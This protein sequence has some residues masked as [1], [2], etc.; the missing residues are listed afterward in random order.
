MKNNR[1]TYLKREEEEEE[2]GRK[3]RV[4]AKPSEKD[5]KCM[6]CPPKECYKL[7]FGILVLL[8]GM[9]DFSREEEANWGSIDLWT[10]GD[11][12]EKENEKEK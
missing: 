3:G 12:K 2:E 9:T 6:L 7:L 8:S 11:V 4:K 1:I 10:T 5:K